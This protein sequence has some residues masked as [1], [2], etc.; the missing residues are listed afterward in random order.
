MTFRRFIRREWLQ[1]IIL[2]APFAIIPFIW[3]LLPAQVPTH[4]GW[5]GKANG[6]MS[7]DFGAFM[8]PVI[9]VAIALL[10]GLAS[11]IDPK[12]KKQGGTSNTIHRLRLVITSFFLIFFVINMEIALSIE[13]PFA[14]IVDMHRAP[15]FAIALLLMLVGHY[16]PGLQPNYFIGVRTPWTLED[17]ENW[18]LTHKMTGPLWVISS[19]AFLPI[20]LIAPS[21]VAQ[22]VFIAYLG[23]V[24]ILPIS[25]SFWIFLRTKRAFARVP[26]S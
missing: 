6:W 20:Y 5:R 1:L 4:W 9:N 14:S 19:I 12:I 3:S 2:I 15:I 11:R 8:L 23:I 16:L 21:S 24:I 22:A 10:L 7:K 18:R 26:R 13:T 25:Y 17:P